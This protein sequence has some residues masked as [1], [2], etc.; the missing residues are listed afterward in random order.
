MNKQLCLYLRSSFLIVSNYKYFRF[1]L[2]CFNMHQIY[3]NFFSS[4]QAKQKHHTQKKHLAASTSLF[5]VKSGLLH[6]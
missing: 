1:L 2:F 5:L 4:D 6:T 3:E